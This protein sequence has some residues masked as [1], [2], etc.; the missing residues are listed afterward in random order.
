MDGTTALTRRRMVE[1]VCECE[2]DRMV[3]GNIN[4]GTDNEDNCQFSVADINYMMLYA[5]TCTTSVPKFASYYCILR[6][7]EHLADREPLRQSL[8]D[9]L[10]D[11]AMQC[12]GLNL[13]FSLRERLLRLLPDCIVIIIIV[14]F[15]F[16]A[17]QSSRV[18]HKVK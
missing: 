9:L 8:V 10:G 13:I 17:N 5:T 4:A 15:C 7:V 6:V 16:F 11:T 1:T 2:E 18:K 14:T 3:R 12:F